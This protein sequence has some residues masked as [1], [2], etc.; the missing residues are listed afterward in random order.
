MSK[1]LAFQLLILL[2]KQIVLVR[3]VVIA[4]HARAESIKVLLVHTDPNVVTYSL[5]LFSPGFRLLVQYVVE[6]ELFKIVVI[7]SC[8]SPVFFAQRAWRVNEQRRECMVYHSVGA[9]QL[10]VN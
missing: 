7:Q 6:D 4:L 1:A 3:L 5:D 2:S 9:L 10:F 8:D